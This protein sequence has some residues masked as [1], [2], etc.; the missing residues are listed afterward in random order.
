MT[1]A[2]LALWIPS[3]VL[4]G[5]QWLPLLAYGYRP[6]VPAALALIAPI[7]AEVS[8]KFNVYSDDIGAAPNYQFRW[9]TVAASAGVRQHVLPA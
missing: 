1:V 7:S 3:A 2:T 9:Q 4:A 5:W 8:E 6:H